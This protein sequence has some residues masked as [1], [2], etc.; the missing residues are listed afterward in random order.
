[1][2]DYDDERL[3]ELCG[4]RIQLGEEPAEACP[5]L[6]FV[7]SAAPALQ[8]P[9]SSDDKGVV[10]SKSLPTSATEHAT[11]LA[12]HQVSSLWFHQGNAEPGAPV[13][14]D[15]RAALPSDVPPPVEDEE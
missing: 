5:V 12:N 6:S 9:T 3:P 4:I 7:A 14:L 11:P 13:L 15:G 10:E 8:V 1:M 2:Y